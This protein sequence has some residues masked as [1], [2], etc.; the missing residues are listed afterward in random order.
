MHNIRTISGGGGLKLAVHEYG[1]PD[2][3]AILL[4]HGFTACHLVWSKQYQSA[5]ADE[6]RLVC[7]DNRGHGMSEKPTAMEHYNRAIELEP[8]SFLYYAERGLCRYGM[9]DWEGAE[10]DFA[11]YLKANPKDREWLGKRIAWWKNLHKTWQD[12]ND[13]LD[14]KLDEF[15]KYWEWHQANFDLCT[16]C[17][18]S[19]PKGG[20]C[21]YCR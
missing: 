3:K 6:F 10:K 14:R 18:C 21:S 13:L 19:Y 16:R 1:R 9:M 8:H 2:G 20:S 7:L 12:A 15:A 4:I 17:M 5:L 11:V